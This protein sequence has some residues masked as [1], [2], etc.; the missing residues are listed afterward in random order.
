ER[1]GLALTCEA[2]VAG[3]GKAGGGGVEAADLF[4]GAPAPAV[5]ADGIIVETPLPA[6]PAGRRWGF[7][8]F[9]RRRGDFAMAAAAVFYDQD[10]HGR[11]RNA[12]VGVIGVALRPLALSPREDGLNGRAIRAARRG[13]IHAAP[14]AG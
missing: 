3:G 1:P 4:Q 12:H 9:A 2:G 7:E 6:W 10:E 11:A 14:P 13:E 8:E 5:R